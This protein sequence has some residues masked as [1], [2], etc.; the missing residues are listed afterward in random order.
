M[1]DV[2]QSELEMARASFRKWLPRSD[3]EQCLWLA[4]YLNETPEVRDFYF[5]QGLAT[6][7]PIFSAN[8]ADLIEALALM[9]VRSVRGYKITNRIK[10]A[11]G[12]QKYRAALQSNGK[13]TYNYVMSIET[14]DQIQKIAEAC[15]QPINKTLELLIRLQYEY[16]T[17][18]GTIRPPRKKPTPAEL[19][20][21]PPSIPS[22]TAWSTPAPEPFPNDPD[23][24]INNSVTQAKK[25]FSDNFQRG[26]ESSTSQAAPS[27]ASRP[28]HNP[29]RPPER[30]SKGNS[31]GPEEPDQR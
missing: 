14:G 8:R 21:T 5:R 7:W 28:S 9:S 18:T 30:A 16:L 12:Q 4:G 17:E 10:A 13:K 27:D 24:P 25:R 23:S 11:W 3:T 31:G 22:G 19:A 6:Y 2:D 29:A 26:S 1:V 15:Q 20:I